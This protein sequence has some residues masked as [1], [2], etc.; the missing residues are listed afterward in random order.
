VVGASSLLANRLEEKSN[1]RE[2]RD[3][4]IDIFWSSTY[5]LKFALPHNQT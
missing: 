3:M 4:D 1:I 2:I 5:N